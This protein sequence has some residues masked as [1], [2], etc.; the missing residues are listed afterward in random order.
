LFA[1]QGE[2]DLRWGM[3]DFDENVEEDFWWEGEEACWDGGV[4][5]GLLEC[6]ME[7]SILRHQNGEDTAAYFFWNDKPVR[8][9]APEVIATS[10]A[11]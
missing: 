4:V 10:P 6:L 1:G 8:E 7:L 3:S 11:F 2:S 5:I 9:L